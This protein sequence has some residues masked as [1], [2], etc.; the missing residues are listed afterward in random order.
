VSEG[1][2]AE[3]GGPAGERCDRCRYWVLDPRDVNADVLDRQGE[4][5]RHA[6]VPS[7]AAVGEDLPDGSYP[8]VL[9]PFTFGD[10]WCGDFA[11]RGDL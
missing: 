6:P 4:C 10:D 7:V 8:N 5:H 11:P 9:W 1:E 2:E 3:R